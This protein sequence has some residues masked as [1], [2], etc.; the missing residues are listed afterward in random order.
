MS[1][2]SFPKPQKWSSGGGVAPLFDRLTD[3]N[4]D[5]P[6][7]VT[8]LQ[9][10]TKEEVIESVARETSNL[11]NTRCALSYKEY[12]AMEPSTL[13]YGVPDL[14]GFFDQSYA[15]P[16]RAEDVIKLCRFMSNTIKLF[17]PRLDNIHVELTR[18]D[19]AQQH[20]YLMV[21]ADLILN[22]MIDSVSFPVVVD[23]V[24]ELG[25]AQKSK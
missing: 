20:A 19:Q 16:S 7:E 2:T 12:E 9:S 5:M 24:T 13:T 3:Q 17:E 6:E 4:P 21:S 14:Y 1:N 18:Y 23:Q 8:P 15:D 11:L 25:K 22:N 10:Y